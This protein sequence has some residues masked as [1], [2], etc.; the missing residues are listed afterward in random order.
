VSLFWSGNGRGSSCSRWRRCSQIARSSALAWHS[1]QQRAHFAC[2][3]GRTNR[4]ISN[5]PPAQYLADLLTKLG[6]DHFRLQCI[7]TDRALYAV[8]RY[9]DFL[10][11]RRQLIADRLNEFLAHPG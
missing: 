5:K 8:D 3:G 2:I 7:P 10:E 1:E 4:R 6:P 9:P 11:A